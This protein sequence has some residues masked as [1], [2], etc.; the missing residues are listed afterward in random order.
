MLKRGLS[1]ELP[2]KG[3]NLDS[4]GYGQ[5]TLTICKKKPRFCLVDFPEDPAAVLA[6]CT[7]V[8][9]DFFYDLDQDD[10]FQAFLACKCTSFLL[11]PTPSGFPAAKKGLRRF[12]TE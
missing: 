6:G 5:V 11:L 2:P 12:T 3:K 7:L 4:T 9:P 8:N 1:F 10:V